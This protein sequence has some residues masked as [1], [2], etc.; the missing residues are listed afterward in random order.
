MCRITGVASIGQLLR[1]VKNRE[2]YAELTANLQYLV[3]N[4]LKKKYLS[5]CTPYILMY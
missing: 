3:V 4:H 2:E 1:L 5:S